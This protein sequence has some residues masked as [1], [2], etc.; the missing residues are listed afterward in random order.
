VR[1]ALVIAA[2]LAVGMVVAPAALAR[3]SS[4][5]N[6]LRAADAPSSQLDSSATPAL[7]GGTVVHRYSQEVDGVPVAG[8]GAVVVDP[9]DGPAELLFDR[10]DA[11]VAS[12]GEPAISSAAA[13][14]GAA[15]AIGLKRAW[16]DPSTRLV[17]FDGKL[18][19]EVSQTARQPLGDF[20]VTVDAATGD[21]LDKFNM[22]REATGSA[23]VFV[24]NPVV[25]QDGY[26][27]L[28]DRKDKDSALLT[29][30]RTPVTLEN[31]KDGQS[32]LKGDWVN[33]KVGKKKKQ[34]CKDSLSWNS[35]TRSDNRFEALMAYYHVDQ[36]Q[37]YI[38]TFGLLPINE[39]SQNVVVDAFPD[40]N[41]FYLPHK[42]RIEMGTGGVDDGEDAEVFVHE[43]GHAV[44]DAQNP[45]AFRSDA[46]QHQN[47]AQGEGF[48]DYFAEAYA[49]EKTGFDS[50]WSHCVMEWDATS[51]DDQFTD[52]PGICL[53][54][55]DNPNT[56]SQ[57]QNVCQSLG[58]GRNEVHC[59]GEVWSSALFDLRTTLG[60]DG[61]GDS[62]MDNVV[63]VS[64]QLLPPAPTFQDASEALIAADESEY[65]GGD[66]CTTIRAEMVSRE[67]LSGSFSC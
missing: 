30:L 36:A 55:T 18:A 62:I 22:I 33:V 37:Q 7:P 40:D 38:Q 41:S 19:W 63:L 58:V 1:R 66:H 14:A 32:C 28:R 45:D 13:E 21:V 39:E 56:R 46:P 20:V 12:P 47:G 53:R 49:T 25:A 8:A 43:Y 42:D 50:E 48:G 17:I 5:V 4:V 57:Q 65:G 60:D 51:Y 54:R 23:Q 24:P 2:A 67:L 35:V 29:S 9:P 44:Q 10:T 31:I 52:P 27:G 61:G 3:S 34:V 11:N 64:H 59:M 26:S 15:D 6:A 16:G